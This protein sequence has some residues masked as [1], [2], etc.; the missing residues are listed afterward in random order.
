MEEIKAQEGKVYV[1]KEDYQR[2]LNKEIVGF[3]ENYEEI[4][5]IAN[6]FKV[7]QL[8]RSKKNEDYIEID[9]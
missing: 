1:D 2:E 4:Y 5:Y 9:E 3:D 7:A 6:R 8:A